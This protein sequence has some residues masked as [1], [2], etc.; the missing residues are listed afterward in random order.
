MVAFQTGEC[1]RADAQQYT[2]PPQVSGYCRGNPL[3]M[4][5]IKTSH[6]HEIVEVVHTLLVAIARYPR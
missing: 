4:Q 6:P 1:W 5:G 3:T 2:A